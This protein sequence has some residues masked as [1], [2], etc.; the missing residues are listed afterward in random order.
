MPDE[1]LA[2]E[3]R[4]RGQVSPPG[5]RLLLALP[6]IVLAQLDAA[7]TLYGQSASYWLGDYTAPNEASPTSHWLLTIHPAAFEMGIVLWLAIFV[8][9]MLLVGELVALVI[10]IAVAL[11]HAFGITTW[12][13]YEF[14][15]YQEVNA[16]MLGTAVLIGVCFHRARGPALGEPYSFRGWPAWRRYA[17]AA[18]LVAIGVYLFLIPH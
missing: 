15:A 16:L 8:G 1:R 6:G 3:R 17:A 18:V 14:H 4:A 13:M 5:R 12:L 2:D 11:G 7:I 10:A 9:A